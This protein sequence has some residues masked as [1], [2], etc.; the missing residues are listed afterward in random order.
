LAAKRALERL[1]QRSSLAQFLDKAELDDEPTSPEEDAAI[2]EAWADVAAGRL[3]S[4]D[5]LRREL[6]LDK[7]S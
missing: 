2:A 1:T 5:D 3:I 4:H 7:A 6:G